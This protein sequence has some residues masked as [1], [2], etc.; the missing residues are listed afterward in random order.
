MDK[1]MLKDVLGFDVM[2]TPK[3]ITIV[4]WLGLFGIVL[5]AVA[6]VLAGKLLAGV[7]AFIAGAIGWRIWCELMIVLFK[8]NQNIQRIAD[9]A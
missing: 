8:I 6:A 2:L 7:V 4:Y 3:I 9:K 1:G 5:G